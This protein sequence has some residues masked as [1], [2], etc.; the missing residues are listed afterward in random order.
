MNMR[1]PGLK[2]FTNGA[3]ELDLVGQWRFVSAFRKNIG[4]LT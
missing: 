4:D 3:A 2:Q 1:V